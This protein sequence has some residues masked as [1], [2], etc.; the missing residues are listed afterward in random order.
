MEIYPWRNYYTSYNT[1]DWVAYHEVIDFVKQNRHRF[2]TLV[3]HLFETKVGSMPDWVVPALL[4]SGAAIGYITGNTCE[5]IPEL[6]EKYSLSYIFTDFD[7]NTDLSP[8][9]SYRAAIFDDPFA[10]HSD[11]WF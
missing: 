8:M 11:M 5:E 4:E 7:C 3:I 2:E 10:S 6:Q 9:T 1:S